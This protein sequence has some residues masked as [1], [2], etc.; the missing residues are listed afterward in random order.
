MLLFYC[1][2]LNQNDENS[3]P[4]IVKFQSRDDINLKL[5]SRNSPWWK[6]S[7]VE[8]HSYS[9]VW[10][11]NVVVERYTPHHYEP[12]VKVLDLPGD[13]TTCSSRSAGLKKVQFLRILQSFSCSFGPKYRRLLRVTTRK[14]PS[15]HPTLLTIFLDFKIK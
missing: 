9:E 3:F 15:K 13:C 10:V 14:S 1:T 7:S 12:G 4:W 11:V 2:K 8:Y 5:L 6:F